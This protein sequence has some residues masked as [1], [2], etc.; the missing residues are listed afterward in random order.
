MSD[1]LK[2]HLSSTVMNI[3][4]CIA[5][6][7]LS[8]DVQPTLLC[9]HT[10]YTSTTTILHFNDGL[11]VSKCKQNVIRSVLWPDQCSDRWLGDRKGIKPVKNMF[12][13]T[14]CSLLGDQA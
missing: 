6:Q 9:A 4:V 11:G 14:K 5:L 13:N 12:H 10:I 8:Y 3:D 7:Q 2:S 1:L